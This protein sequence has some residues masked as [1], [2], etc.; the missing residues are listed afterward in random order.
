[1]S[2]GG[3]AE[4]SAAEVVCDFL[5]RGVGNLLRFDPAVRRR[6]D[7]EGVHQMRVNVRHLRSELRVARPALR[8]KAYRRLDRE[9]RWLGADLG[10]LRDLDVLTS[11]FTAASTAGVPTPTFISERLGSQHDAEATRVSRILDSER[12]R[13][14]LA[15]LSRAVAHPPLRGRAS[16]PA[17]QVLGPGLAAVILDFTSS[18]ELLGADPSFDD[19]HVVRIKAKRARYNCELA[20]A[21]LPSAKRAATKLEK[22]QAALGDL[23]D[24]VVARSFVA[25]LL[26][27]REMFG[28]PALDDAALNLIEWLD[29]EVARLSQAWSAQVDAAMAALAPA[30]RALHISSSDAPEVPV[31]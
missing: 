14:L 16:A 6:R 8:S 5:G 19:L 25:D 9:L 21:F 28:G 20:S 2:P 17:S 4:P 23:H 10:R 7:P 1:V 11:L 29:G 31:K 30:S 12:Y 18:V 22:V 26:R 13:R 15:R 24:H 3:R 27:P